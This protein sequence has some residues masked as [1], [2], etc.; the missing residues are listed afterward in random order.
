MQFEGMPV[1]CEEMKRAEEAVFAR[2]VTAEELM[3]QAGLYVARVVTQFFPS[4]GRCTV[5]CGKGHNGGDALVAARALA[6]RGWRIDLRLV[7]AQGDLAPLTAK[8]LAELREA[9]QRRV[10][11]SKSRARIVLDGLLGLGARRE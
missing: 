11:G 9:E 1:T 5:F 2:G 7:C 10:T 8:K 4:P 6:Q 3:E